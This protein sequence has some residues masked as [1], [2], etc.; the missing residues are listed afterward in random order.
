ML[1]FL[2]IP[3][4]ALRWF[5]TFVRGV[6]RVTHIQK[7]VSLTHQAHINKELVE[8]SGRGHLF[9]A[10]WA[11]AKGA[12]VSDLKL[13]GPAHSIHYAARQRRWW[14]LDLLLKE[15]ARVDA[16]DAGGE[17][18]LFHAIASGSASCVKRLLEAGVDPT[19][20]NKR[21]TTCLHYASY[22]GDPEIVTIILA[23]IDSK[24]NA[25]ISLS[26]AAQDRAGYTPLHMAAL[27]R[28]VDAVEVL[29]CNGA[30]ANAQSD[31]GST[32]LHSVSC[33]LR[34]P[35]GNEGD[36]ARIV[37]MLRNAGVNHLATDTF[38]CTALHIA[39]RHLFLP[40]VAALLSVDEED[41]TS[42]I[43]ALINAQD[44]DG[45]HAMHNCIQG[46]AALSQNTE[47]IKT[48]NYIQES[49]EAAKAVCTLLLQHGESINCVDYGNSTPLHLLVNAYKP[50]YITAFLNFMLDI[51]DIDITIENGQ[52]WTP[53]HS[54]QEKFTIANERTLETTEEKNDNI[55]EALIWKEVLL[56]L[57]NKMTPSQKQ[58][59][60]VNKPKNKENT[61]YLQRRGP[62]NLIPEAERRAVLNGALDL[63][64][65]AEYMKRML[66]KGEL[67]VVVMTGA[68]ISVNSGIP[69]YRSKEK[70]L[71]NTASNKN[72]MSR[73]ALFDNPE[74]F[75]KKMSSIFGGV[76]TDEIKPS[77]THKFI[78]LLHDKQVLQRVYTQN[79]DGLHIISGIPK[80]K[81]VEAH[82]NLR[83]AYCVECNQDYPNNEFQ[84][85]LKTGSVPKC[86][87]C[88]KTVHPNV[89]FFGEPLRAQWDK[90]KREDFGKATLLLVMGT[91]LVVYPF[92]GLVSEVPLL[93]PR[94]LFNA[95]RAGV[96]QHVGT[97]D[98]SNLHNY[99]DVASVG[100]CD[101][102]SEKLMQ[103]MEW[104][105]E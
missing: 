104:T 6:L 86:H 58:K 17:T 46:V 89:V 31:D 101:E 67:R 48:P 11:L 93:T 75:Y 45:L 34:A 92:A 54:A 103:F 44:H 20:P 53:I 55:R 105:F 97:E 19:R 84:E 85:N 28:K 91:S 60:D 49:V 36:I 76:V 56:L 88:G 99:R 26:L 62:H 64:G 52:G 32:P 8:A 30:N 94:V 73:S 63:K 27:Q 59:F 80:E 33:K 74:D 2:Y 102:S 98:V 42:E 65:I 100:D 14:L 35:T 12:A 37:T 71:Y 7:T 38:G 81:V 3:L 70:G 90:N 15:G 18:A 72:L 96:F 51:D 13:H 16:L 39:C 9:W 77:T 41:V 23:A 78:K 24:Q 61:L 22:I 40:A 79:I 50:L 57:T 69:D 4:L 95:T 68:G 1:N 25:S 29:L 47:D 10:L 83:E 5:V 82:G 66:K 43:K 87:A 21:R